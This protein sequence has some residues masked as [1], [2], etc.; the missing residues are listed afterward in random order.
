MD[1]ILHLGTPFTVFDKKVANSDEDILLKASSTDAIA[2][3]KPTSKH[4]SPLH[5]FPA[6]MRLEYMNPRLQIVSHSPSTQALDSSD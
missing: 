6:E 1:I 3:K 4:P 2:V 5:E